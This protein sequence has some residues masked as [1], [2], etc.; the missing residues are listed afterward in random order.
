MD[1][2]VQITFRDMESSPAVTSYVERR[3]TKLE[4]LFDR[5]VDCHVVVEEP[6]R[7]S[8]QGKKFHVRISMHVPGKELVVSRNVDDAKEDLHAA[9][10]DA[11]GD[12]ERVLEE[13]AR[14][15]QPDLKTHERPTRGVVARLFRDEGYGFITA[16]GDAHDVYFHRNSVLGA[17]FEHLEVGAKVRFAEEDGEKGPQA[18]TVHAT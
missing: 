13:H 15:L 9:I 1:T 11:F 8:R 16:E 2:P 17:R 5:L 18:S 12:A 7:R 6:H 10:D 14:L 3:A 4:K